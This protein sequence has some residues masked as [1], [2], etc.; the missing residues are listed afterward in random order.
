MLIM[1]KCSWRK[2]QCSISYY[3]KENEYKKYP[4]KK[5]SL[6]SIIVYTFEHWHLWRLN[7]MAS[8][9]FKKNFFCSHDGHYS[10]EQAVKKNWTKIIIIIFRWSS[11]LLLIMYLVLKWGV[12]KFFEKKYQYQ[13]VNSCFRDCCNCRL[14]QKTELIMTEISIFCIF[15]LRLIGIRFKNGW[16]IKLCQN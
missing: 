12:Y 11:Y 5:I 6:M 7:V 14:L 3:L 4:K 1:L 16:A 10:K 2:R 8:Y 15:F 9:S 13:G